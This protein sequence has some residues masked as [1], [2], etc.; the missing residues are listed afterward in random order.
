MTRTEKDKMLAG[1]LYTAND[2]EIQA[3]QAAARAWMA[4]FNGAI[5]MP[6]ADRYQLMKERFAA[7]G[8]DAMVRPPFHCDYGYNIS[9]GAGVFMNYG[10]T[11]LDVVA[12]EIGDMTQIATGVQILTA[13]HPRDPAVRATGLE[14]GRP[15]RIGRNVW[16][17][18]GA[19]ILPGV[20]I[21]DDALIGAGSIV[22]RDVAAGATAVGNPARVRS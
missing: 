3:D 22:T 9:L 11:I 5:D 19:I 17:G 12:V 4:R 20:T 1:E 21:G 2:A 18:A 7:V 14:L 16:I 6:L 13:D 10:C 8:P 15:V